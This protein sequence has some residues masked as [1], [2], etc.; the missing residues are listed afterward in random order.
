M[1]ISQYVNYYWEPD[2][3]REVSPVLREG[4][5][6]LPELIRKGACFLPYDVGRVYKGRIPVSNVLLDE[7][8]RG[9]IKMAGVIEGSADT[10]FVINSA[11][12][13]LAGIRKNGRDFS[14]VL[15][16]GKLPY[17]LVTFWPMNRQRDSVALMEDYMEYVTFGAVY[18]I[19]NTYFGEAEE[20]ALYARFFDESGVNM[21]RIADTLDFPALADIIADEFY[22]GAMTIPETADNLG[23]FASQ[24]FL[25]W[26]N[27]VYAMFESTGEFE[28][29]SGNNP[30][31]V[32]NDGEL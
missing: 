8:E 21:P 10:F 15:E 19:R 7:N 20:F 13:S 18:P 29:V 31:A 14:A 9:W 22:T 25:S 2:T 16:S 12:R 27:Q 3:S 17:N 23:A 11:A 32:M 24:S 30:Q 26:L 6:N 1:G 5:G 28:S 4:T